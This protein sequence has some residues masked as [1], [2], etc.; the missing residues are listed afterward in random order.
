[1]PRVSAEEKQMAATVVRLRAKGGKP[2]LNPPSGLTKSEQSLFADLVAGNKHLV[3][4]DL[5][6]L[7]CYTQSI[8]R[9]MKLAKGG[10][11]KEYSEAIKA[12]LSL[13]RA[14]R[15]T[16]QSGMDARTAQRYRRGNEQDQAAAK[17][18]ALNAKRSS[19]C[20]EDDDG[21][22]EQ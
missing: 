12:M 13:A 5:P 3:S 11:I 15:L 1:M 21:Q 16:A 17:L 20:D 7:G 6:I 2:P 19:E 10:D 8:T 18:F 4:T 14:C 9:V 22:G